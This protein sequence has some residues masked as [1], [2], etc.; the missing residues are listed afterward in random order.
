MEND[1]P[2]KILIDTKEIANKFLTNIIDNQTFALSL[3]KA[4]MIPSHK[5]LEKQV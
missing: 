1:I 2:T 5:Q 4:D 3:K